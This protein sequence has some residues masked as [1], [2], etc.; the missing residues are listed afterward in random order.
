[1]IHINQGK[2]SDPII[3][4][5]Y[6]AK[7]LVI[8]DHNL[9]EDTQCSLNYYALSYTWGDPKDTREITVDGKKVSVTKNLRDFL[10]QAREILSTPL[11]DRQDVMP[12]VTS[13]LA[14]NALNRALFW[15]DALC[16]NQDDMDEKARQIPR[17]GDIY[18]K[19]QQVIV[20]LGPNDGAEMDKHVGDDLRFAR[21]HMYVIK[22]CFPKC[23]SSNGA[24]AVLSQTPIARIVRHRRQTGRLTGLG[25]LEIGRRAWFKR[26]WVGQEVALAEG[27]VWVYAGRHCISFD[28][29]QTHIGALS[30]GAL[31]VGTTSQSYLQTAF[32]H[33]AEMGKIRLMYGEFA[34]SELKTR[35]L[36]Q[37]SHASTAEFLETAALLSRSRACSVPHD[38]IY[39]LLG[40]TDTSQLPDHLKPDYGKKFEQVYQEYGVYIMKM[41]GSLS[42]LFSKRTDLLNSPSWVPDFRLLDSIYRPEK[43]SGPVSFVDNGMTMIVEGWEVGVVAETYHGELGWSLQEGAPTQTII[44]S[45]ITGFEAFLDD[46]SRIRRVPKSECLTEWVQYNASWKDLT[47]EPV[48]SGRVQ[49]FRARYVDFVLG[50]HEMRRFDDYV[51]ARFLDKPHLITR[52]GIMGGYDRV[53]RHV[54]SGDLV[55]LIKGSFRPLILRRQGSSGH[56]TLVSTCLLFCEPPCVYGEGLTAYCPSGK[57]M[58][59][60]IV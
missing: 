26:M 23:Y 42:L 56:Y 24:A 13:E 59:F 29:L 4:D 33:L 2:G 14:Q 51:L 28:D 45:I 1:L 17:M 41:T 30:L 37:T 8:T 22:K 57:L 44:S 53:D 35:R 12:L 36:G 46:V 58:K 18:S 10:W 32:G 11:E 9:G 40:M 55:C 21:G 16:I 60:E 5:I 25:L 3:C 15:I 7:D 43:H 20:W 6:Y 31:K 48:N 38:K 50:N 39:G 47:K 52:D 19:A 54:R 27:G 34:D 49:K